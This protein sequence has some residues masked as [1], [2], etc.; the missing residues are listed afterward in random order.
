MG[1]C[2]RNRCQAGDVEG[3]IMAKVIK[4]NLTKRNAKA[5]ARRKARIKRLLKHAEKLDW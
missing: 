3:H 2:P 4:M 5:A 1:L